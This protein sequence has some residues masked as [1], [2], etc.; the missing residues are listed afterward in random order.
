MRVQALE[1]L[2]YDDQLKEEGEVFDL[3]DDAHFAGDT[4][5]VTEEK[6]GKT[7]KRFSVDPKEKGVVISKARM[8]KVHDNTELGIPRPAGQERLP[9]PPKKFNSA[10]DVFAYQAEVDAQK[11]KNSAEVPVE[12]LPE[13]LS[14]LP[15]E[16]VARINEFKEKPAA[17]G[18]K[19]PKGKTK[20]A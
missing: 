14:Q 13:G 10:K 7:I 3:T 6:N 16:V 11:L 20:E 8:R 18:P 2:L 1:R 19:P 17:T 15:E 12:E 4:F 5:V 9:A